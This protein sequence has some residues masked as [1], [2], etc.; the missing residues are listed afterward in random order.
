MRA[1]S[2]SVA[3]ACLNTSQAVA[4]MASVTTSAMTGSAMGNPSATAARPTMTP[5]DTSASESVWLAS[6]A[7]TS[8]LRRFAQRRS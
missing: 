5:T 8:L 7:S 1:R 6:A 4:K 2:E 3:S